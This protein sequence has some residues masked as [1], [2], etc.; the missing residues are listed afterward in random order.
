L[1]EGCGFGETKRVGE[2]ATLL[3]SV[4]RWANRVSQWEVREGKTR[5]GYL[6]DDVASRTNDERWDAV[7]FEVACGQ[8]DR[9]VTHRSKRNEDG[10][11]DVIFGEGLAYGLGPLCSS[12]LAIDRWDSGETWG[13]RSN[14]AFVSERLQVLERE[15]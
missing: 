8:T 5:N 9:L 12:A 10:E 4:A 7:R 11:I 14:D 6:V 15:E 13:K 1:G 2:D 3:L